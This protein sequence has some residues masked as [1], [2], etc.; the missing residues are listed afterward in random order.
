MLKLAAPNLVAD[1]LNGNITDE[2]LYNFLKET[3]DSIVDDEN[4]WSKVQLRLT[5]MGGQLK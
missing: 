2:M 4:I 5:E 3:A 1:Y